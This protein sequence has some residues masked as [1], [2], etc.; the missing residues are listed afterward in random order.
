MQRSSPAR[1]LAAGAG[2]IRAVAM[3]GAGSSGVQEVKLEAVSCQQAAAAA[4]AAGAA[5]ALSWQQHFDALAGLAYPQGHELR[6]EVDWGK[7]VHLQ[8]RRRPH[9]PQ[10]NTAVVLLATALMPFCFAARQQAPVPGRVHL[11]FVSTH[12]CWRAGQRCLSLP[13]PSGAPMC[14]SALN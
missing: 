6:M 2:G 5:A 11:C 12:T 8:V 9:T 4:G 3:D 1:R 7:Q 10:A 14:I 13:R